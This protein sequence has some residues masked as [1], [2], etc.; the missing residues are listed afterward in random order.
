[1]INQRRTEYTE[2]PKQKCWKTNWIYWSGDSDLNLYSLSSIRISTGTRA[3]L[4]FFLLILTL[5]KDMLSLD[6]RNPS[7]LVISLFDCI[8]PTKQ[9][10]F[11]HLKRLDVS[12]FVRYYHYTPKG[13]TER[14]APCRQ[15]RVRVTLPLAVYRQSV[16]W[17]QAPW[18][19]RPAILRSFQ[20]N[21]CG[22][23]PYVTFSLTREWVSH[24]QLLLALASAVILRSESRGTHGH[25]SLSHI[26]NSANLEGQVPVFVSPSDR[27]AQL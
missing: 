17:W 1:M 19:S 20:P 14:G 16:A 21:L 13:M 4:R 24:F 22:Y 8:H 6:L 11:Y 3:I 15:I 7:Q 26:R 9:N 27:M 10:T 25:I 5:Y 18:D 12:R 2:Q 23:S